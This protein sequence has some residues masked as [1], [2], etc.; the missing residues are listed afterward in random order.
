LLKAH[1][2]AQARRR[3]T[4]DTEKFFR[5]H[6]D[7]RIRRWVHFIRRPRGPAVKGLWR[8]KPSLP[9]QWAERGGS[10]LCSGPAAF[11]QSAT[12]FATSGIRIQASVL[13]GRPE[14]A[15]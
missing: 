3:G 10:G 12:A 7:F 6:G 11:I 8:I 14:K 9:A 1:L 15:E 13:A 4:F 5:F 2:A